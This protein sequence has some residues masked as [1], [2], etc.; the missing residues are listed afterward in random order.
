[1]L[2]CPAWEE[3][4]RTEFVEKL[5]MESPFVGCFA[6]LR[7]RTLLSSLISM[8]MVRCNLVAEDGEVYLHGM[9]RT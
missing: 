6:G 9:G 3:D 4:G 1:M 5:A 8:K 2:A 7:R